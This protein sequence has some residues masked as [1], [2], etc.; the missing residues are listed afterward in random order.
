MS[1][2]DE[3]DIGGDMQILDM[4]CGAGKMIKLFQELGVDPQ[5]I[6]ALDEN[7]KL[8]EWCQE[9]WSEITSVE[10]D[11]A[12]ASSQPS[13]VGRRFDLVTA[14]MLVNLL[15]DGRFVDTLKC[16][17]DLV[18]PGGTLAFLAPSSMGKSE[19]YDLDSEAEV[20]TLLHEKTP[21]GL[22]P[23]YFRSEKMMVG[24]FKSVGFDVTRVENY[25][26]YSF[27]DNTVHFINAL[28]VDGMAP[29]RLLMVAK[30][31]T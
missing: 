16:A 8:L 22:T 1:L 2:F 24:N 25:S 11:C 14:N 6:T 26:Y 12:Q 18:K 19:E 10:S 29:K 28:G 30:K 9:A 17:Y 23:Y 5:N 21:W 31:I 13:L 15:N 27:P 20:T 3:L 4:G 7:P